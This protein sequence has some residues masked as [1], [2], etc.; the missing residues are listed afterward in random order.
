MSYSSVNQLIS[1]CSQCEID[2]QHIPAQISKGLKIQFLHL[3]LAEPI[4][5]S[6]AFQKGLHLHFA[7]VPLNLDDVTGGSTWTD[8]NRK[9]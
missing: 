5:D 7:P 4:A 9:Q 8:E 3:L 2:S 1:C 6:P